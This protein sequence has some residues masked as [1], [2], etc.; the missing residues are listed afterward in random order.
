MILRVGLRCENRVQ[1]SANVCKSAKYI[2][3]KTFGIR[4]NCYIFF[5]GGRGDETFLLDNINTSI[6]FYTTNM[7]LYTHNTNLLVI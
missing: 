7:I 5:G 1:L 3:M 4:L 6:I 2:K